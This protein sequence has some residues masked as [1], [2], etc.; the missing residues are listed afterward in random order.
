[1]QAFEQATLTYLDLLVDGIR[2]QDQ[3]FEGTR[4]SEEDDTTPQPTPTLANTPVGSDQAVGIPPSLLGSSRESSSFPR[5][6]NAQSVVTDSQTSQPP[7]TQP[8]RAT[9]RRRRFVDWLRR[10]RSYRHGPWAPFIR[11][12]W[13]AVSDAIREVERRGFGSARGPPVDPVLV[14]DGE[15]ERG[16]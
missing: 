8:I 11:R 15:V 5:P 13:N 10:H 6:V 4:P 1:M 2:N 3:S 14:M 12:N 16:A 9:R 7:A